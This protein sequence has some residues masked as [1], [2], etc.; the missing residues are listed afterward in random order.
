MK[1]ILLFF[2]L[3]FILSSLQFAFAKCQAVLRY[4]RY[5]NL[6]TGSFAYGDSIT[7]FIAPSDSVTLIY[8]GDSFC[9]CETIWRLNG[10]FN[11]GIIIHQGDSL[12]LHLQDGGYYFVSRGSCNAP[13]FQFRII[14][15]GAGINDVASATLP[16]PLSQLSGEINSN[17]L[18]YTVINML[19][20][21]VDEGIFSG[22][23]I[24]RNKNPLSLPRGIYFVVYS[25]AIDNRQVLTDRVFLSDSK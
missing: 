14:S 24:L 15:S 3:F 18:R 4:V 5:P 9:W 2:C 19:G 17:N 21:I 10:T 13:W 22:E 11:D 20:K 16:Y 6:L 1:K 7:L 8:D 12:T 25:D 23:I